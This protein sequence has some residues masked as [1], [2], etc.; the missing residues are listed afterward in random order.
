[1]SIHSLYCFRRCVSNYLQSY[2]D[3]LFVMPDFPCMTFV[4]LFFLS[5]IFF[6]PYILSIF[7]FHSIFLLS[8][9]SSVEVEHTNTHSHSQ[10]VRKKH[11]LRIFMGSNNKRHIIFVHASL[12]EVPYYIYQ[13]C[14]IVVW[15]I[16][17]EIVFLNI[18]AKKKG[19][20]AWNFKM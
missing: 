12:F 20:N 7:F 4:N 19:K 5:I 6:W 11:P 16:W 14:T 15:P 9:L 13:W 18:C 1:M 10:A 8:R 2:S 3:F 17:R